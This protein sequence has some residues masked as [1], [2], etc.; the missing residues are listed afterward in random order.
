MKLIILA[1]SI[2]N[3][4]YCVV[5][6]NVENPSEWIRLVGDE[7]GRELYRSEIIVNDGKADRLLEP[8]DVVDVEIIKKCPLWFQPENAVVTINSFES[9]VELGESYI[10]DGSL[11]VDQYNSWTKYDIERKEKGCSL[12][13]IRVQNIKIV[14]EERIGNNP[15]TRAS[16]EYKGRLYENFSVTDSV[17]RLSCNLESAML[18]ISLGTPYNPKNDDGQPRW[19]HDRHY[20]II[21]A[22]YPCQR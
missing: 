18:C 1:V 14:Y 11:L 4:G 9:K 17:I 2:K 6:K 10:D 3:G 21:A 19:K 12:N 15:K 13:F 20:K 16:F 5:G 22:V 8:L 7:S